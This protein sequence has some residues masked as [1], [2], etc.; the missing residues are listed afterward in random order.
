MDLQ[1]QIR[2]AYKER[3]GTLPDFFVRAPGRVNLIGEHTD[4]NEGFVLPMAIDRGIW[5]ALS[6]CADLRVTVHSLDFAQTVSFRLNDIQHERAGWVEYLKG[7]AWALQETGMKLEGWQGV[8]VGNVPVGAGLASSAALEL[9][10]IRA[11]AE[12]SGLYWEAPLMAR[13]AQKAENDW[14]GVRCGIMDQMISA[15]GVAGHAVLIDCRSLEMQNVS[16]PSQTAVVIMDTTT[17]RGLNESAYNERRVQCEAA[18]AFFGVPALRDVSMEMFT[19]HAEELDDLPRKRARHVITE[20]ARTLRA[21]DAMRRDDPVETGRLMNASHVSLRNE[22]EVSSP[23]LDAI[24]ECAQRQASCYG[25][26]MT[27]AGF[28]GCAVAI[29]HR[30]DADNFVTAVR[31][32]YQHATAGVADIF[33]SRASRGA[34]AIAVDRVG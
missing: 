13:L 4:Y 32:C 17:R 20:N 26:R 14:V 15:C 11:F 5:L 2:Q 27:G 22:F 8:L 21:V 29:V 24:V 9:A 16:L 7:A 6:P 28:G 23:E 10:A 31:E 18:A 12:V 25:A 34:D 33:I 1:N 19:A 3:Y 30:D